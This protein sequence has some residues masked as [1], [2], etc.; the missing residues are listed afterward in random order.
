MII[1]TLL[2]VLVF[3]VLYAFLTLLA[4][5]TAFTYLGLKKRTSLLIFLVFSLLNTIAVLA[6]FLNSIYFGISI[7]KFPCG[8]YEPCSLAHNLLQIARFII[9]LV[10][11]I[12]GAS[13]SKKAKKGKIIVFLYTLFLTYIL[14]KLIEIII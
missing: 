10:G 14:N 13:I 6:I 12:I 8:I 1:S 3:V 2:S 7:Y 5:K 11:L 4:H 9:L